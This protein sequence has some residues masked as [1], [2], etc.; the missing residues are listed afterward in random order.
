MS[1]R[2]FIQDKLTSGVNIKTVNGSSVLGAGNLVVSGTTSITQTE[3]DFGSAPVY[4]AEFTITDATCTAT[5]KITA[6]VAYEAPTGKELD[7]LEMDNLQI[8]CG[9]AIIGSFKMFVTTADYSYLEG[10]FKINYIIS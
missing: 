1:L 5:S 7:E 8:R 2:R 4:G 10:K 6:S 9:Q 3:I